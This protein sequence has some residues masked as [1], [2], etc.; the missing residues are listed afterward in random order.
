VGVAEISHTQLNEIRARY[1]CR[2]H[3]PIIGWRRS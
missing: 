1:A 2:N 3:P